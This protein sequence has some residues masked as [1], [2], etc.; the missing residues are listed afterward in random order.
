MLTA[1]N[2]IKMFAD[3]GSEL[4]AFTHWVLRVSESSAAVLVA[5]VVLTG[6][7][8]HSIHLRDFQHSV[9]SRSGH[10]RDVALRGAFVHA[11]GL[12]AAPRDH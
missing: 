12:R 7:M 6:A 4:P 1:P 2:F 8:V 5:P 11:G 10:D 3:M 9:C